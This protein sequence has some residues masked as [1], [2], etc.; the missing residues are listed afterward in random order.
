MEAPDGMITVSV[1]DGG[2]VVAVDGVGV[3]A[4]SAIDGGR[5][6]GADVVGTT[7]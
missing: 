7:C 4:I 6:G 5:D 3:G 1:F 2:N